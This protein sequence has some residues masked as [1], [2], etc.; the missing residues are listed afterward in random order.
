MG[1]PFFGL[2]MIEGDKGE[3]EMTAYGGLARRMPI[4]VEDERAIC[5]LLLRYA[6]SI[7]TRDWPLF[8]TC[9]SQDCEADY[10]GFGR[11][12]GTREIS[13]YMEGLH[14]NLGATLHRITNIVIEN[15]NDEVVARCYV[16]ALLT[17]AT[18]GGITRR[19]AGYFDDSFVRT[20]DGWK[21][22]RRRFTIVKARMDD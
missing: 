12:R 17:D 10:G 8:R 22:A 2:P 18:P 5:N 19:A 13:E 14:R 4:M 6:T 16:D 20:S 11:W 7:D 3:T 21:I 9:F 1:L 15:C